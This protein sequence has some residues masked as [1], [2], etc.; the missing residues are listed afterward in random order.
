M[1]IQDVRPAAASSTFALLLAACLASPAASANTGLISFNGEI[2]DATCDV[3]GGATG[4]PSFFVDLPTISA[5]QL[6]PNEIAGQT[7]FRMTL[8]NCSAV[9][10]GVK[11]YF[12]SGG[13]VDAASGTLVTNLPGV[14]L[15]LFDHDG[16]RIAVGQES[17]R[18]NG[19]V[20]QVG[21]TMYYHVAYEN[22]GATNASPGLVAS[23]VVYSLHYP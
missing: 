19:A 17:Q 20:Y 15:A 16:T 12:Q 23:S 9:A 22:L 4:S 8:E 7:Q 21:D 5:N 10:N 3:R 1:R 13:T 11:A 2:T 18:T 6:G 14:H